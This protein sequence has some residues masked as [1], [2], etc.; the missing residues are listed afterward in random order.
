M[1]VVASVPRT[2]A[3]EDS[4]ADGAPAW[5]QTWAVYRHMDVSVVRA[6]L[7]LRPPLGMA[8]AVRFMTDVRSGRRVWF[9]KPP[10]GRVQREYD[11]SGACAAGRRRSFACAGTG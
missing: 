6:A 1:A 9:A 11:A 2:A 3:P 8:S 10:L 5:L 4:V 7:E